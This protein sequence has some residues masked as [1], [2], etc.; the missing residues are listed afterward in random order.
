MEL[1]KDFILRMIKDLTKSIA[2]LVLG[3]NDL[4]FKLPETME[5]S[6][7]DDLYVRLLELVNSGNINDAEDLLFDEIN[8]SDM[9]Q[10][11]MALSF[12]LYLNDF[13]DDYLEGNDYSRDEIKEGLMSICKEYGV[14]TLVDFL[15]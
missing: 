9:R 10:F 4:D 12:Y 11:E 14:S 6:R 8:P 3:K 7:V 1:E 2:Y 13:G 5:Y 15:F